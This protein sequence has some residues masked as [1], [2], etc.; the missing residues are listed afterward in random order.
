MIELYHIENSDVYTAAKAILS[1]HTSAPIKILHTENGKP[2]LE[3]NP[4]FF[5]ISHS[6]NFAV[7]AVSGKP[8]GVDLELFGRGI[9]SS[10]LSR[11]SA[12][13]R[14]EISTEKD[15]LVHWTA[16]E[17][18]IKLH[19]LTL[20]SALNKLEYF[21]GKIYFNGEEQHIYL[22]FEETDLGITA[23]CTEL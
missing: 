22:G 23:V 6:Q 1:R 19:G 11:F 20:A 18:F 16:R 13:E 15:F 21:G 4:L 8:V 10:V 7:I 5:S 2:Y 14:S 9:R 3:G 12:R 17:A